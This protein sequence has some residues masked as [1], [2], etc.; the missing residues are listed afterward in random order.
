MPLISYIIPTIY[1]NQNELNRAINSIVSA[2]PDP[3]IIICA[4]GTAAGNRNKGLKVVRGEWILFLDD[5]DYYLPEYYEN[6]LNFKD[7][8]DIIVFRM[9]QQSRIIPPMGYNSI[10]PGG[11]GINFGVNT[12]YYKS[13]NHEFEDMHGEDWAF[14]QHMHL[15]NPRIKYT[16]D[17]T[18]VA[19]IAQHMQRR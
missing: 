18:Y 16:T 7:E 14:I 4:G 5:D 3:D 15:Q 9:S 11:V 8:C 17:V 1:R 10:G 2:D 13:F 19:P 12:E 6:F